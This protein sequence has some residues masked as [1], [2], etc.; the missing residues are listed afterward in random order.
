MII[1]IKY[2]NTLC[3]KRINLVYK[4][5]EQWAHTYITCIQGHQRQLLW[6][7]HDKKSSATIKETIWSSHHR[8]SFSFIY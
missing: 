2:N 1:I 7:Y 6:W 4:G 3:K 5:S 8:Q